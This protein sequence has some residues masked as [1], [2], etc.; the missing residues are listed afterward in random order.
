[1]PCATGL[2]ARS[3]R[4]KLRRDHL[5]AEHVEGVRTGPSSGVEP[6][7]GLGLMCGC[8]TCRQ[9]VP[10]DGVIRRLVLYVGAAFTMGLGRATLTPHGKGHGGDEGNTVEHRVEPQHAGDELEALHARS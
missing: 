7:T 10:L 3:G 1:M 2:V 6:L 4:L 9:A 8:A 5:A